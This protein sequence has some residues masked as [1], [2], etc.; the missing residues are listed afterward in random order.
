MKIDKDLIR[1][2]ATNAK[3]NLTESEINEFL[4]QLKEYRSAEKIRGLHLDL[5]HPVK[6]VHS[7]VVWS[8]GLSHWQPHLMNKVGKK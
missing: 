7:F 2:V 6:T 5:V 1:K 4:P 8:R 3:L